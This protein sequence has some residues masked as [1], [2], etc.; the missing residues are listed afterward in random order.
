M[1]ETFL[2]HINPVMNDNGHYKSHDYPSAVDR[3]Q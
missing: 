3:Q 2:G 1:L